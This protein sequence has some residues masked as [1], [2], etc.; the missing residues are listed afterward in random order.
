MGHLKI[1]VVRGKRLEFSRG[2]CG[3]TFVEITVDGFSVGKSKVVR[4][5]SEPRWEISLDY[6]AAGDVKLV[7]VLVWEKRTF[8]H[9]VCLGVVC[10]KT[11]NVVCRG[12]VKGLQAIKNQDMRKVGTVE[13][14]LSFEETGILKNIAW[15]MLPQ[16]S[17]VAKSKYRALREQKLLN[18]KAA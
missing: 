10:V 6:S 7:N 2:D 16:H 9:D 13:M 12:I 11:E 4:R 8:G 1:R 15:P 5:S 14:K 18:A 3:S 17:E